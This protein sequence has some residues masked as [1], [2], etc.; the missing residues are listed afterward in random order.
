M[1]AI[2]RTDYSLVASQAR[3]DVAE[4]EAGKDAPILSTRR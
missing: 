2:S 4:P 1:S 3:Q